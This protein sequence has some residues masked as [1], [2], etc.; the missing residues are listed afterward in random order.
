MT[1]FDTAQGWGGPR[2]GPGDVPGAIGYGETESVSCLWWWCGG[3]RKNSHKQ[4][5]FT[6][7]RA[8]V[9]WAVVS[10]GLVR[11]AT[12]FSNH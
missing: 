1:L 9:V 4:Q 7:K 12:R 2:D 10:L 3:E 11:M 6:L 8:V 5:R